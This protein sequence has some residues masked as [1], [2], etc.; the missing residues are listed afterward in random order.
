MKMRRGTQ[1][2][3]TDRLASGARRKRLSR[4]VSLRSAVVIAT[5]GSLTAVIGGV[6]APYDLDEQVAHAQD[7]DATASVRDSTDDAGR[8]VLDSCR[9]SVSAQF[10]ALGRCADERA[11]VN[12]FRFRDVP[13]PHRATITSARLFFTAEESAETGL[14]LIIDGELD[15]AP[16]PFTVGSLPWPIDRPRTAAD[17]A[18]VVPSRPAWTEG[19]EV[20]SAD[21]STV[22]QEIVKLPAWAPGNS[23]M[24]RVSASG[25]S[26]GPIKHRLVRS[27]DHLE[28]AP[29]RLEVTFTVPEFI[30]LPQVIRIVAE[31]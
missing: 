20:R 3:P 15:V 17:I 22:V 16:L 11:I 23:M 24:I 5:L 4:V 10:I 31:R 26:T 28:G 21:L 29:P 6:N 19:Q 18:W 27:A 12:G 30:W 25:P 7:E 13:L 8:D 14:S 1:A 9:L 2:R